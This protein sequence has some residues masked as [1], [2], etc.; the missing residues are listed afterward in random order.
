MEFLGVSYSVRGLASSMGAKWDIDSKGWYIPSGLCELK[1][2]KLRK[3]F[4]PF[5]GLELDGE[6]LVARSAGLY[7][8]LI[9][10]GSF[11]LNLRGVLS[12]EDWTRISKGVHIRAGGVCECCG[13]KSVGRNLDTHE[14]FHF[15]G[16]VQRL[17]CLVGMCRKCH[18]STHFGFAKVRGLGED[19]LL[20]LMYV[21]GW[22]RCEAEN[23]VMEAFRVWEERSK[24]SWRVDLSLIPALSGVV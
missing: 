2:E 15:D 9:P 20:H 10:R 11:T 16:G 3:R 23:H 12:G 17:V 6:D 18:L 19:A 4:P 7:V 21:R 13:A 14:R 5:V 8:D 24:R 22:N 1:A